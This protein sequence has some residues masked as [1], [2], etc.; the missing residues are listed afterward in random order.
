MGEKGHKVVQVAPGVMV[1]LGQAAPA[2]RPAPRPT[3][4]AATATMPEARDQPALAVLLE[5]LRRLERRAD[6]DRRLIAAL[7]SQLAIMRARVDI[8]AAP[9]P[10]E[11]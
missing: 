1:P 7:D 3:V 4:T 6:D 2:A 8:L 11:G 9:F 5:R 10:P